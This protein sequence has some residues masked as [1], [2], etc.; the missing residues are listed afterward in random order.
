MGKD[1][2]FEERWIFAKSNRYG[3][4]PSADISEIVPEGFISNILWARHRMSSG[5]K[6]LTKKVAVQTFLV[7]SEMILCVCPFSLLY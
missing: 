3:K 4:W 1:N 2:L 7:H 5:S 6:T